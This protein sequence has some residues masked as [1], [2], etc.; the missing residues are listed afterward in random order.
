M[1]QDL[2]KNHHSSII[3]LCNHGNNVCQDE[4]RMMSKEP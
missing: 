1:L 2:D 3:L 4:P